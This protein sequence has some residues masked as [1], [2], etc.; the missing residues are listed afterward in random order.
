MKF[1]CDSCHAQ[2]LISD[3]KVGPNGVIVRCKKCQHK[4]VVKRAEAPE[5]EE[6]TVVAS[7]PGVAA[8]SGGPPASPPVTDENKVPEEKAGIDDELG[9]AFE[10]VLAKQG[11]GGGA[12]AD[13]SSLPTAAEMPA[14]GGLPPEGATESAP[15]MAASS[16]SDGG[17]PNLPDDSEDS[18]RQSTRVVNLSQ[19][20]SMIKAEA[21]Q[22][23]AA[24]VSPPPEVFQEKPKKDEKRDEKKNG[25]NGGAAPAGGSDWFVA[26][27]D[28]QVGPLTIEGVGEKWEKGELSADSLCWKPGMP[29]WKP[30]SSVPELAEKLAPRPAP[31][32]EKA[33][34]GATATGAQAPAPTPLPPQQ[35][36]PG[37]PEWK[38]SAASALASLVQ[39][40]LAALAKPPEKKE[41]PAPA[42]SDKPRGLLDDV[43]EAS[44]R[45]PVPAAAAAAALDLPP[46]GDDP[47]AQ[48]T[49]PL[50]SRRTGALPEMPEDEA[51]PPAI[52]TPERR[53]R[54][55]QRT[56]RPP[57]E[58][59]EPQVYQPPKS[60]MPLIIGGAIGG[61][62][63]LCVTIIVVVVL[64]RSPAQ[65]QVIVQ[66]PVQPVAVA[67]GTPPV[68]GSGNPTQPQPVGNTKPPETVGTKAPE[69]GNP[70]AEA[71]KTDKP[72]EPVKVAE[73]AKTEPAKAEPPKENPRPVAATGPARPKE[74]TKVAVN[75]TPK[76]PPPKREAPAPK[77]KDDDTPVATKTPTNKVDSDF[78]AIFGGDGGKKAAP[79]PAPKPEK[80]KPKTVYIPP[81]PGSGATPAKAQLE[82]SD[83]MAVVVEN[84]SMIKA[85]VDETKAKDPGATGTIAMR[86]TIL[87][88]GSVSNIQTKTA[89]FQKTPLSACL[90]AGIKKFKFP[91]YSGPQMAP[92]DFP[93]KF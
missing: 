74:P 41:E 19:M 3:E 65:P 80:E 46:P 71:P 49:L 79:E 60:N 25:A 56:S 21:Q 34:A 63:L 91:A 87:P 5:K 73:P 72:G 17:F 47:H 11:V 50:S 58:E 39:D 32:P 2:Y 84:K 23:A 10:S 66:P 92:V 93:F 44:M 85:C 8:P 52:A 20:A 30:L 36:E 13:S 90:T 31:E 33:P 64:T 51:P 1:V 89:E 48:A 9:R 18:D 76:E 29:D 37:E 4:I 57:Y 27:N 75:D 26:I 24:H 6:A 61:V 81:A 42:A 82:Q 43:P 7:A 14:V 38:P 67:G 62:A 86:W 54:P 40:E 70:P 28:A 16:G 45:G 12:P 59:D 77:A 22:E 83:I 55:P 88:N 69:T 35:E 78:D 15:A 68:S 53:S